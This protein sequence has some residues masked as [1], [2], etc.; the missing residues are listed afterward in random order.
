MTKGIPSLLAM[1]VAVICVLSP[2][3]AGLRLA[4]GASPGDT[5]VTFYSSKGPSSTASSLQS[6]GA[7]PNS[8]PALQKERTIMDTLRKAGVPS[9]AIY[10]P[11][12]RAEGTHENSRVK[13]L[14][15]QA[16]APMGV[17]DIGVWNN[18]GQLEGY[19]FD[20]SSTKGTINLQSADSMYVDGLG[21][22]TFGVQLNTVL[23]GVTLFGNPHYE[24]WTQNVVNY[25][26]STHKMSFV[27]NIWNFS[28]T[29]G[30]LPANSFYAHSKNGSVVPPVYYYAFGPS[31]TVSLPFTLSLYINASL[32]KDRPIVYFNYTIASNATGPVPISGCYDWA[33]FNSSLKAPSSPAPAPFFQVNGYSYNP[34]GLINDIELDTIGND[35]GDTT[36][37]YGLN[38]TLSISHWNSTA[39]A[40][41]PEPAAFNCGT[42]TGE[43]SDGVDS[44]WVPDT[45]PVAHVTLGPSFIMGL[46]NVS[47]SSGMYQVTQKLSPA[48]AFVFVNLGTSLNVSGSQWV[49]TSPTGTTVFAVP[50][51]TALY[52]DYLMSEYRPVGMVVDPALN[53]SLRTTMAFD[54]SYGVYTPLVAWGNTELANISSRGYGTPTDPYVLYNNQNGPLYPQFSQVNGYFFPVFSGILLVGTNA[55]VDITPPSLLVPI[56]SWILAQFQGEGIGIPTTNNLQIEF[57]NTQNAVLLNGSAITGW[58]WYY[59]GLGLMPL[60][61]VIF[62]D[63]SNN[64]VASNIFEDEGSSIYFYGGTNNTVWGNSFLDST[65]AAYDPQYLL[66]NGTYTTGLTEIESGDTIYNNFFVVPIPAMTFATDPTTNVTERYTEAWNIPQQPATR[67]HYVDGVDLTGSIINSA[68]QGGNFWQNYGSQSDPLGFL[69]YNDNGWIHVGGDNAPLIPYT[70][71]QVTASELGLPQGARWC[72]TTLGVSY[73]SR[74]ENAQFYSPNGT[75][76]YNVTLPAG[77]AGTLNG[78]YTVNGR[79]TYVNMQFSQQSQSF[80]LSLWQVGLLVIGLLALSALL[81]FAVLATAVRSSEGIKRHFGES[82]VDQGASPPPEDEE[83]CPETEHQGEK[84]PSNEAAPASEPP[85]DK[86]HLAQTGIYDET[87]PDS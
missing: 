62:W 68:Y 40:Y 64:L 66:Y 42:D 20:T 24:F 84:P 60:A 21:P 45:P 9:R 72:F 14:Y 74:S 38:A 15:T 55:S 5:S 1:G 37:F 16:P 46:W 75:F 32:W 17:A 18:S 76:A 10:L 27:D 57:L 67:G 48:N 26:I 77:Y 7:T 36:T 50:R 53:A 12:I 31:Y 78:T 63:S 33:V 70:V 43:T 3:L 80:A 73:V 39:G 41:V 85:D 22:D 23:N 69:P 4:G 58:F 82:R 65:P 2:A 34:I 49:P 13:E 81:F 8:A 29:T 59:T 51:G 61:N 54:T 79:A 44:Y 87:L 30:N 11:N 83:D 28:D 6:T 56:P 47:G 52:F 19:Q 71:Y 35:N 86:L 25:T